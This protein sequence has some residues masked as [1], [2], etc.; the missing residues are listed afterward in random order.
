MAKVPN[1][2]LRLA[3]TGQLREKSCRHLDQARETQARSAGCE[4]RL[5]LGERWV[6]LRLG[7]WS[8]RLLQI[9]QT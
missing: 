1:A 5:E 4:E 6:H 2:L 3:W 7:V 8:H 9:F